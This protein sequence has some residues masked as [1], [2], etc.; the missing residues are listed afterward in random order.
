MK[1]SK[2]DYSRFLNDVEYDLLVPPMGTNFREMSAKQAR[3]Y[4]DWFILHIPE[5]MDYFRT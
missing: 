4:N 3:E 2:L 1:I 5:R